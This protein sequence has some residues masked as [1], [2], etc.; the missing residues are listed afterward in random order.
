[1]FQTLPEV[2]PRDDELQSLISQPAQV[3]VHGQ[4]SHR[5]DE[6]RESDHKVCALAVMPPAQGG[7]LILG[8]HYGR[9][10][11]NRART[12]FSGVFRLALVSKRLKRDSILKSVSNMRLWQD[13]QA[14]SW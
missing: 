3:L 9:R 6:N 10:P 11:K 2:S 4:Y 12:L 1:M 8:D 14:V 13:A 7:I 5:N